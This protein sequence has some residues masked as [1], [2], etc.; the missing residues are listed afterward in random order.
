MKIGILGTG[1]VGTTIGSKLT[2]RGQQVMLGSRTPD[3]QAAAGWVQS[4][5]EGAS[6]GTFA[7]AARFGE[8][9]FNCTPGAVSLEVLRQAGEE[10]LRGKILI[11][12]S[13]PL[14]FSR[15]M[16]PSLT[17]CNTDSLGEQIQAALPD[18]RVVKTLNTLN[19][20]IMVDPTLVPGDHNLFLSGNDAGAKQRVAE[21]LGEWFGWK[22]E[23]LIDLGDISTARG[24]EMLL[25]LWVRL[26]GALQTPQFNFRVVMGGRG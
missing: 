6:Q 23:N 26:L 1:T 17:V 11:D 4:A 24:T 2:E 3:N 16:P 22:R 21:L 7:D 12:V 25:P 20:F 10:N 9:V 14:D 13:N 8:V 18:T 5:G 19:C 15:G